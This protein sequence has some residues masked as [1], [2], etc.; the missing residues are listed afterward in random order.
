MPC[1]VVHDVTD[2][3]KDPDTGVADIAVLLRRSSRSKG[4]TKLGDF[5]IYV[6][7]ARFAR[8]GQRPDQGV[9]ECL[10]LKGFAFCSDRL[11]YVTQPY[12]TLMLVKPRIGQ[13]VTNP[14]R[15]ESLVVTE[16]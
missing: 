15:L 10:F 3:F 16:R 5:F 13:V 2:S 7:P 1:R 14:V 8:R 12:L 11:E 4:E 9:L 6:S